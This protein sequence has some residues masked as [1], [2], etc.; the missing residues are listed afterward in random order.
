MSLDEYSQQLYQSMCT[1]RCKL[2]LSP[3]QAVCGGVDTRRILTGRA[4]DAT[5]TSQETEGCCLAT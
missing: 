4:I 1:P 5:A 2:V 3:H